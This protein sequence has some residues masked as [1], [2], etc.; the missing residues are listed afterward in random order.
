MSTLADIRKAKRRK[1]LKG[2]TIEDLLPKEID[3]PIKSYL[4]VVEFETEVAK[5]VDGEEVR[6]PFNIVKTFGS[7][8]PRLKTESA[9]ELFI[10]TVA[11]N[12]YMKA[13]YDVRQARLV[14]VWEEMSD[15]DREGQEAPHPVNDEPTG[16]HAWQFFKILETE[17]KKVLGRRVLHLYDE[18]QPH[19]N[20]EDHKALQARIQE[21]LPKMSFLSEDL[22]GDPQGETVTNPTSPQT[23]THLTDDN[24]TAP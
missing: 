19:R 11:L 9:V 5:E 17:T 13:K 24:P 21:Q 8:T 15:E 12:F 18:D 22:A 7:P 20:P 16:L 23:E 1:R 4:L 3:L 6:T 10:D 2:A 14:R